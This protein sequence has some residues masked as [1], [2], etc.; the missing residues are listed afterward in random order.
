MKLILSNLNWLFF[1]L[2]AIALVIG[3]FYLPSFLKITNAAIIISLG[4]IVLSTSF[5]GGK[6]V[7]DLNFERT[8]LSAIIENLGDGVIGYDTNFKIL[9]FNRAAEQ[10][11][12]VD[13]KEI[14]NQS[15]T[16]KVKEGG[17]RLRL[18]LTVLF[19]ALAESIVRRSAPG[20]YPQV[21]DISFDEPPLDLRVTTN[22]ILDG[23][24]RTVGFVKIIH[25]RS[26]E[27]ILLKAKSEFITIASHQLRTPLTSLRWAMENLIQEPLTPAQRE[28]VA[29]AA[30]ASTRLSDIVD[31]LI[32]VAKIEEGRFGYQ[33]EEVDLVKFLEEALRSAKPVAEARKIKLY[34]TR[35]TTSLALLHADPRR[36]G[37][38]IATLLDNAIRYNIE[39]GEV[40]VNIESLPGKPY[41]E[42]SV[43][44]TGIGI[45]P[46]DLKKI[47]TEFFRGENAMRIEV[48]G[49][50][51]ALYIAKNIIRRHGGNMRVESTINR[52]STFSFTLPTDSKLIPAKE[53][54]SD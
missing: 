25:D 32:D 27:I 35:P 11:F 53:F 47:F 6:A 12:G 36:L 19:P 3:F 49:T 1:I 16:M 14:L 41:V 46:Q 17:A 54:A 50:G 34:L 44:D 51:L 33:F 30:Q 2:A 37:I 26:R 28:L 9:T 31:G 7:A 4:I 29:N 38:V 45:A 40:A 10:I 39:N 8:H 52:G 15:F 48:E 5:Y 13:R 18:I 42:V 20:E 21:A 23:K 24:S 22:R 43:R